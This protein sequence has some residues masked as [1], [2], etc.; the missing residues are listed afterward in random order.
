M[1]AGEYL[2]DDEVSVTWR[3]IEGDCLAVLP[4]LAERIDAVLADPPYG[5]NLQT[6]FHDR[7][8]SRLAKSGNYAP[9]AGDDRPFDPAHLLGFE[10]IALFG[11]NYFAQHLPASGHWLVWDKRDGVC[12]NDQAD[13][14]LAWARGGT[15]NTPRVFRHL[16]MGMLKDSERED[17]RVHPTQKPVA[18]MR[19]V[20]EQMGLK[21]GDT[22]LDP[23]AGSGSTGVACVQMGLNFIGIELDPGYAAIARRRIGEAANH[24]FAGGAA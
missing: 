9:V 16:W 18:L 24:L 23:Y 12:S 22:V 2:E 3:V 7:G 21:P 5:V 11:A 14:E 1:A 17:C 8:C 10:R 19:W 15:R 6:N 13:A 20:I 4:T